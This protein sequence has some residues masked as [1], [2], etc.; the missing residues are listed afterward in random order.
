MKRTIRPTKPGTAAAVAAAAD[1]LTVLS[2]IRLAFLEEDSQ[3]KRGYD[4]YDTSHNRVADFWKSQR[5]RT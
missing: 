4:P 2:R 1:P 3:E 5:K